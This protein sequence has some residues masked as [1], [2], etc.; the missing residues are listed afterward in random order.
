MRD[1]IKTVSG[2]KLLYVMAAEQEYGAELKQRFTPLITGVGP[3]EAAACVAATLQELTL[4]G[5][6]PDL[7]VSLGSAGSA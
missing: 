2:K 3:V 6:K 1:M 4:S 7:V 5:R